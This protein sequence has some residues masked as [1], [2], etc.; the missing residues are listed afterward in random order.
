MEKRNR[1]IKRESLLCPE[2][3]TK[4]TCILVLAVGDISVFLPSERGQEG[5]RKS[6]STPLHPQNVLLTQSLE[7]SLGDRLKCCETK[8]PSLLTPVRVR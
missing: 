8:H 6:P 2:T 5:Q 1:E 3:R 7:L 4:N